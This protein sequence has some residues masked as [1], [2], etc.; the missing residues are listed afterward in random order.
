MP[1]TSAADH[2][3]AG[4]W[5]AL[6]ANEPGRLAFALRLTLVCCA[7]TLISQWFEIPEPAL[8][9]YLVLFLNQ[10]ERMRSILLAVVMLAFISVLIALLLP[11][12][13][14]LIDRPFW[15]VL[16]MVLL[17]F[18]LV[19]LGS[20]S[21]LKPF[22]AT[23]AL[24]TAYVLAL[25]GGLPG[26]ELATRGLLYA[27][28]FVAVPA[29]V[30]LL[31]DL[32]LAPAPRDQLGALLARALVAGAD[33]LGRPDAACRQRFE[34]AQQQAVLGTAP[35]LKLARTEATLPPADADAFRT[36][37]AATMQI[38]AAIDLLDR[39]PE[40]SKHD[41]IAAALVPTLRAMAAILA[42]GRYPVA[43]DP[44]CWPEGMPS[45][46]ALV[47]AT[48]SE[49]LAQF[50]TAP[51]PPPAPVAHKGGFF[52]PDAFSNPVHVQHALKVTLAAM[53]GYFLYAL[54]DWSGIHTAMITCY[55]VGL[56]TAAETI[57]KLSLRI[58]GCLVGAALGYATIVFVLPSVTSIAGLLA[59]VGI[60]LFLACWVVAGDA[61]ISYAGLQ[62]AFAFLLCTLQ[63]SGPGF[64]LT[65]ARDR[66]I[67]VLLGTALSYLVFTRLWP[68]SVTRRIDPALTRLIAVVQQ[69]AA[70]GVS[71]RQA[72]AAQAMA[73]TVEL[74]RWLDLTAFEPRPLR[75]ARA[76]VEARRGLL[77]RI[78]RLHA[79]LLLGDAG[80]PAEVDAIAQAAAA[81]ECGP[82]PPAGA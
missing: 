44:P 78:E 55:I 32:V 1:A 23:M 34:R 11:L 36:G 65:I 62:M 67:G 72:L 46:L 20:A 30:S 71:A 58:T 79:P 6:W 2:P 60:G 16:A 47:L 48:L 75:P 63:G 3:L 4:A 25:L 33:L 24:I 14:F 29:G 38:L 22:A 21:R 51:P 77:R 5:V 28:L 39:H 8:T 43:I 81:F 7:T 66:V 76:S 64:D 61:R 68:V 40:P 53:T 9:V 73:M 45:D 26:G 82:P 13:G 80:A 27:W 52:V 49:A 70:I 42:T 31:A 56:G 41:E 57:Q 15:R 74:G 59:V 18:G 12:T 10:P 54:W 17:S 37:A 35:L 50:T 19:F 69:S